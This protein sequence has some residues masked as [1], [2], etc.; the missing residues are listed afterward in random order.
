MRTSRV[1]CRCCGAEH[2]PVP[3]AWGWEQAADFVGGA[4]QTPPANG[5]PNLLTGHYSL[6]LENHYTTVFYRI[7]IGNVKPLNCIL[8]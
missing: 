4:A 3:F 6:T 7:P 5:N 2:G 1:T 8:I